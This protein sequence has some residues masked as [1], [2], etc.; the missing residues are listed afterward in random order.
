MAGEISLYV[1]KIRDWDVSRNGPGS[2]NIVLHI[3]NNTSADV[4]VSDLAVKFWTSEPYDTNRYVYDFKNAYST[5]YDANSASVGIIPSNTWSGVASG[6]KVNGCEA[7]G[8]S[9]EAYYSNTIRTTSNAV[10][11][12][13][14][15]IGM[16]DDLGSCIQLD[17]RISNSAA[18][19]RPESW[20]S[21]Q[22]YSAGA[23]D[24]AINYALYSAGN[25]IA[26]YEPYYINSR[27]DPTYQCTV[28][29]S[30][31]SGSFSGV[32]L[33][34]DSYAETA[35]RAVFG[36]NF[37]VYNNKIILRATLFAKVK[38]ES[39]QGSNVDI[40]VYST[41][42]S[43]GFSSTWVSVSASS[44]AADISYSAHGSS[45]Q[46]PF[47]HVFDITGYMQDCSDTGADGHVVMKYVN[48]NDTIRSADFEAPYVI[49]HVSPME[50]NWRLI[51]TDST[52]KDVISV[53]VG[54]D[55]SISDRYT[56][57]L[58]SDM[59]IYTYGG[60]RKILNSDTGII[61]NM[62]N[63]MMSDMVIGAGSGVH[64]LNTNLYIKPYGEGTALNTNQSIKN[65]YT[66]SLR[67]DLYIKN[68][69]SS[70]LST[71]QSILSTPSRALRT[72]QNISGI[73]SSSIT[74]DSMI[75]GLVSITIPDQI[76]KDRNLGQRPVFARDIGWN[77]DEVADLN[78]VRQSLTSIIRTPRKT[79]LRDPKYGISLYDRVY[80]L[81]TANA[82]AETLKT[83]ISEI[84]SIDNRVSIISKES[85]IS[86][87]IANRQI[88]IVLRWTAYGSPVQTSTFIIDK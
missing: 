43:S 46:I 57:S 27:I 21:D 26:G 54:T 29:E 82:L 31:P 13:G 34:T 83:T 4:P 62:Y 77:F 63:A 53:P 41:E 9:V 35:K 7:V 11:P 56:Q 65:N 40:G 10:I 68:T 42:S 87:N 14:G 8:P 70:G 6:Y 72:N 74:T 37:G 28:K 18:F 24:P 2:A 52:T 51:S 45:S 81:T 12:S 48:E 84:Q 33:A 64:K 85:K 25:L 38:S 3:K 20:F 60:I 5:C 86:F 66:R 61:G 78:S 69:I 80:T 76:R 44:S 39:N 49:V 88:T 17:Y 79:K 75:M 19:R 47:Y 1:S 55:L 50:G 58:H 15:Y 22:P 36:F 67:A 71:D 73:E 59:S 30:S 32:S 16:P 23:W